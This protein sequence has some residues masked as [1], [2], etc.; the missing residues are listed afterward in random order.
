MANS[1]GRYRD[2]PIYH[3]VWHMHSLPFQHLPQDGTFVAIDKPMLTHHN[4]SKLRVYIRFTLGV[5]DSMGLYK[6]MITY[7][8][9]YCIIL[10]IST[11]LKILCTS[12]V[13]CFPTPITLGSYCSYCLHGFSFSRMPYS[14]NNAVC[15]LFSLASFT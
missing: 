7:L 6:C 13:Y 10:S 9:H 11:T 2:F 3:V 8:H 4:H 12:P 15:S 5:A 1:R 14:W